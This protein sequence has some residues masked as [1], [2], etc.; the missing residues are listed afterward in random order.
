[1]NL[2]ST[3]SPCTFYI[4]QLVI[5]TI[6]GC[7]IFIAGPLKSIKEL[8]SQFMMQSTPPRIP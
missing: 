7:I 6:F 4:T 5:F 2:M 8:F 3:P 1:M